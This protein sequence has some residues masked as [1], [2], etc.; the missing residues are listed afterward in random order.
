MPVQEANLQEVAALL[1]DIY[2]TL[3]NMTFIPSTAIKRGPHK[4]N[5]IAIPCKHTSAVLRLM[6]I[7]PYMDNDEVMEKDGVYRTDWLFGGEFVDY[8]RSDH[9]EEGCE[10]LRSDFTWFEGIANTVALTRWGYGG[11]NSDRT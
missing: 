7:M 11:W 9:L 2:T 1:D 6:E 10:P 5:T 3:V 4:I 8:R